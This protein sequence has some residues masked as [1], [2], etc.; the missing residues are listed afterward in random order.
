MT[1]VGYNMITDIMEI[2]RLE[3]Q[4]DFLDESLAK[5]KVDLQKAMDDMNIMDDRKQGNEDGK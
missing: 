1:L 2:E 5:A 3:K 4:R